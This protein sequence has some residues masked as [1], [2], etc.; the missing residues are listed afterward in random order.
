MHLLWLT[1]NYY[2][3]RGGMAQSCDRI[4]HS[5]RQKGLKISVVHFSSRRR[6]LRTEPVQGGTYTSVPFTNDPP[7]TIHTAWNEI[8]NQALNKK[9]TQVVAFGGNLPVLAA[10][11]FAQWLQ[12]PLVVML[13]G[14]DF[15]TALFSAR[16]RDMLFY[17]LQKSA[18][19]TVVSQ[20]KISKIAPLLP[21]VQLRYTPNGINLTDWQPMQSE[22]QQA[23]QWRN[24]NVPPNRRVIGIF[25]QLKAKK[26]MIFFLNAL[27]KA[28]IHEQVHL[29]IVGHLPPETAEKLQNS[30]INYTVLP[31]LD[32][33]ELLAY[34]PACDAVAIPSFYDGMPNVLLEAAA[35][36]VPVLAS[37]VDGMKDIMAGVLP[38]F[39][40]R[41][42][43]TNSCVEVL[44]N[45]ISLSENTL[46][47]NGHKLKE[48][49]EKNYTHHHEAENFLCIFEEI[50]GTK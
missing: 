16:K 22:I 50:D 39:L 46:K 48:I 8:E 11:V 37:N 40:F 26:G 10:P 17:A 4:V 1:E 49:I 15:D 42:N 23:R 29:L 45:F 5:L 43:D 6:H 21:G 44:Q 33:Y 19:T 24:E 38:A 30:S 31:F 25:G 28:M 12:K 34:Y 3:A 36:G 27:Q 14:N 41:P 20:T 9:C 18:I 35:L 32:R 2:P 7:H 47:E 13:R